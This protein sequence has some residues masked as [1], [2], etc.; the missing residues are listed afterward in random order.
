MKFLFLFVL[1]VLVG[2]ISINDAFA[3][4][5]WGN[6]KVDI[7]KSDRIEGKKS[8]VIRVRA[9]FTNNDNEQITIYHMYAFLDDSKHREFSNSN[10]IILGDKGHNITEMECPWDFS[11]ELNPG[12]SEEGSFCFEVP[13]ENVEFTLHL[14]ESSP[15][16]CKHPSYGS[17]NEKTVRL[18]V[19]P[20]S[21]K[22]SSS[23]SSSTIP[24]EPI[25]VPKAYKPIPS[26]SSP[27]QLSTNKIIIPSSGNSD[28]II[29]SGSI[30]NHEKGFPLA[31][32]LIQPN[33]IIQNFITVLSD[34]GSYRTSISINENSLTGIYKIQL[35]H[36]GVNIGLV[37]FTV[38]PSTKIESTSNIP[39]WIKNN[40]AWWA[41]DQI[42]DKTF[43]QGL[44]FLIKEGIMIIPQTQSGQST[45]QS[46]PSW[47]KNTS[48]FWAEDK[49]S[50]SEFISALQFLVEKG[51]IVIPQNDNSSSINP[52]TRI[53]DTRKQL[54]TENE[55]V[56]KITHGP[57][58]YF[59][60]SLKDRKVK[61]EEGE[62]KI[63]YQIYAD[64][65]PSVIGILQLS[66]NDL[67]ISKVIVLTEYQLNQDSFSS[68]LWVLAQAHHRLIPIE[69]WKEET[70]SVFMP[71]VIETLKEGKSENSITIDGKKI[72]FFN[73]DENLSNMWM[74]FI[75]EY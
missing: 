66:E 47:I 39:S 34:S 33:G 36:K 53:I 2:I 55:I 75:I 42:D 4:P 13:K 59:D 68:A 58:P 41:E 62:N 5:Y 51:I 15:D 10:Y 8:D 11:I 54:P 12:I 74:I 50:D 14:Y 67:G 40:A 24:T 64:S 57:V 61:N 37:S 18:V 27:P 70:G 49:I 43:V 9:E 22:S 44:E 29:L 56:E 6:L 20:P 16:W 60:L 7:E 35:Y 31:V 25:Q 26:A 71:W 69:K 48:G 46:I 45:Q 73:H 72:V 3:E 23:P 65:D 63:T 21:P 17:C 30:A 38:S 19:N 28:E 1:V 52:E 32:N